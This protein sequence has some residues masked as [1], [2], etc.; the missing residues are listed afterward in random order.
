MSTQNNSLPPCSSCGGS[1]EEY[2]YNGDGPYPC[3]Y[4]VT[5]PQP[6]SAAL[7][8]QQKA[9]EGEPR[10]YCLQLLVA[11]GHITQELA[12]QTRAIANSVVAKGEDHG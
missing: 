5:A 10:D 1:G 2:N 4:C 11:A 3:R 7:T 8:A 6:D 12:D 9:P